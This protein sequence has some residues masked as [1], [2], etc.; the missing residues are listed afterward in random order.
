MGQFNAGNVGSHKG[1]KNAVAYKYSAHRHR[2]VGDA[3]GCRHDIGNNAEPLS[4]RAG[5]DST[6]AGN[7][8]VKYQ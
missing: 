8:L 6:E 1:L 3:F 7:D 4:R 2:C 5:T